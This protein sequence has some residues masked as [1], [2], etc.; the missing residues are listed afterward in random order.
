[1]Q[2]AVR[3]AD[4]RHT[5]MEDEQRQL[6]RRIELHVAQYD[7]PVQLYDFHLEQSGRRLVSAVGI[8]I[9]GAERRFCDERYGVGF[10]SQPST[11]KTLVRPSALLDG[12]AVPFPQR[13]GIVIASPEGQSRYFSN[14]PLGIVVPTSA[15]PYEFHVR[16]YDRHNL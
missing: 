8:R 1:L 13:F 4:S 3:S 15:L 12:R 11:D 7:V 2:R 6:E 16:L 9:G 10:F 5:P 14:T